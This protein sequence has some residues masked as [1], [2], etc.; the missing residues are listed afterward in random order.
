MSLFP[1]FSLPQAAPSAS[2][3]LYEDVD[4]DYETGTPKWRNG[5]PVLCTGADAVK[6]WAWRAILTAR[7]QYSVFTWDYA[8]ELAT[9]VGQ[10]YTADTK[11]AEASRYIQ[12]ALLVC[13]YIREVRVQDVTFTGAVLH[14]NVQIKTVYGEVQLHV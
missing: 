3:P 14:L 6:S 5:Q 1:M 4:M 9:L 11:V 2:L 7:Y 10:P 8:C 13:P 12:E